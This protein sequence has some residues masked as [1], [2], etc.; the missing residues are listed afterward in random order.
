MAEHFDEFLKTRVEAAKSWVNGDASLLDEIETRISPATF[1]APGGDIEQGA[2]QVRARYQLDAG[3]FTSGTTNL[4]ILHK[5]ASGDL[6]YWVGVQH[7]AAQLRGAEKTSD[8]ALV[9]TEVFRLEADAWKLIHRHA[10]PLKPK[11]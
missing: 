10:S 3:N 9:V 2:E 5:G 8:F 1:F 7:A 6:G 11:H 4:K